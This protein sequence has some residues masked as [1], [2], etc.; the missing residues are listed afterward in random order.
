MAT[1]DIQHS[2]LRHRHLHVNQEDENRNIADSIQ[3]LGKHVHPPVPNPAP[4]GLIGFGL[5]TCLLQM[6]TTR[7][8]GVSA[9]EMQGVD[10]VILGFA[11]FFGGLL[12]IRGLSFKFH[13]I[14]YLPRITC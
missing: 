3:A 14:L 13:G 2:V 7:I 6:K 5:T 1:K 10:T 11:M 12:Q 8:T 4:L 9:E